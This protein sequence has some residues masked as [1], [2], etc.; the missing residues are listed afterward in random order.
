MGQGRRTEAGSGLGVLSPLAGPRTPESLALIASL[1]RSLRLR[2]G[3]SQR[4]P[5]ALGNSEF[6]WMA[7]NCGADEEALTPASNGWF[8]RA[9]D[10]KGIISGRRVKVW[11]LLGQIIWVFFGPAPGGEDLCRFPAGSH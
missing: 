5:V 4:V 6:N 3:Y 11:A 10:S 2:K 8:T 9:V 7:R 1:G